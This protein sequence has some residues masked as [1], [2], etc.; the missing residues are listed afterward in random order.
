MQRR[1]FYEFFAGGGMARAGL[2]ESWRCLF[3]NDYD[4][5]KASTY[6]ANWGDAEM[7]V[8]DIHSLAPDLLPGHAD[9]AWASF[10]CQDLSLAGNG[11]GLGGT[12]SGA[13]FAFRGL[14]EGLA[15]QRRPRLLVIENVIGALTSNGGADFSQLCQA[16]SAL[17]YSVGALTIDAAHFLPQSRPRLFIVCA[18]ESLARLED[19]SQAAPSSPWHSPALVRAVAN[20]PRAAK[21]AWRW[22]RLPAPAAR[23][24]QLIDV[25]E[26][27]PKDVRWHEPEQTA[28]IIALMSDAN[29][30]KLDET[31]AAGTRAVGAIYRRTRMAPDGGKIQRAEVRFDGLAGCLRTPGGG[32]S[33]QVIMVVEGER[34]RT[35]LLSGR[36]AAR[37]MGLPD[38]YVL[39][40]TYSDAYHLLGDGLAVPAVAF[41][42]RHLLDPLAA[43]VDALHEAAE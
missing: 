34:V 32:S 24:T 21:A 12:R 10:P 28:R 9:L 41:I 39:P 37:L 31:V 11:A 27:A 17:G 30:R 7:H 8:G 13:F 43:G 22:W 23:N 42:A 5:K 26:D 14:I 15:P 3:A 16:L 2:G 38:D 40:A 18:Q 1:G 29:R 20:M 19:L 36:E 6:C 35:R 4:P 33:R 25:T